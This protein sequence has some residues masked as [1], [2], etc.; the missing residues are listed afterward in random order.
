[1]KASTLS[2]LLREFRPSIHLG[3]SAGELSP[4]FQE[5]RNSVKNFESP[6]INL[7][8]TECKVPIFR[9]DRFVHFEI[10]GWIAS[11][12]VVQKPNLSC[13]Y[14]LPFQCIVLSFTM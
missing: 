2:A 13:F 8:K 10:V 3:T 7:Y 11:F 5:R 12:S 14:A 6:R 4:N 9:Q 1:M